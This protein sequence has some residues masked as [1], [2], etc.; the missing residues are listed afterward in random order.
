MEES[1][2]GNILTKL[3]IQLGIPKI[4]YRL[5]YNGQFYPD[6]VH[7][8]EFHICFYNLF[9]CLFK[10]LYLMATEFEGMK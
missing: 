1:Y 4:S 3:I 8:I 6:L 7:D 10:C 9:A 2:E 5:G